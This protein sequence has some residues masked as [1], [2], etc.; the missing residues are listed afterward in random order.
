MV[1]V[2]GG[3][4]INRLEQRAEDNINQLKNGSGFCYDQMVKLICY[5]FLAPCY[6]DTGKPTCVCPESC[7]AIMAQCHSTTFN[8]VLENLPEWSPSR[9]C[10]K[11]E[12][13]SNEECIH[14]SDPSDPSVE[15]ENFTDGEWIALVVS[16]L[17]CPAY[18]HAYPCLKLLYCGFGDPSISQPG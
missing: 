11:L 16:V 12:A 15:R 1:Y 18:L 5:S 8:N 7:Q 9:N 2:P 10:S 17:P 13:I 3:S 14:L 4:D 6:M